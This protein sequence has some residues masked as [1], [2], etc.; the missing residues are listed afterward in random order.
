MAHQHVPLRECLLC[1]LAQS[2]EHRGDSRRE[3]VTLWEL[4]RSVEGM[5]SFVQ[6]GTG[7]ALPEPYK[8]ISSRPLVWM[9]LTKQSETDFMRVAWGPTSSS[10]PCA[11]CP[12][13]WSSIR[14]C[15]W[16]PE[17]TGPPLVPCDF[18]RWEQVHPEHM[19]PAWTGLEKPGTCNMHDRFGGGS[20]MVWGGISMEGG[21]DL[22][23]Q[24]NGT[25]TA[26]RYRYEILGPIARP[27]AGAVGPVFL[28]VH[29][30]AWPHVARV[31]RQ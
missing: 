29:N 1:L 6:G 24:D 15:H 22:Y 7:W 14:L 20:V 16:A 9:S 8:M 5:C 27:Y 31:Y 18:H 30:I 21:T 28:L 23:R 11:H 10:G 4:D 25:L 26:I 13:P 19:W 2:Q 3:A 12:A 17:L